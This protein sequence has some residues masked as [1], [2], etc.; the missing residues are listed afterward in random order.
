MFERKKYKEFAKQQ[1]KNRW[2][3]PILITLIVT[4]ISGL[5]SI[6]NFVNPDLF[7]QYFSNSITYEEFVEG[8][9][10][11]DNPLS[12]MIDF[13]QTLISGILSVA[14]ANVYLKMSRSPEKIT[15]STFIQG[16][17][18]WSKAVLATLW[19]FLWTF[20][21]SLLFIIPGLIKSIA[22][23]QIYYLITE[24]P[25]L[26][27]TKAMKISILITNGHK[28]DLFVMYL[29]FLGWCILAAI[30][31]GIGFIF[32]TPYMEMTFVNAYHAMLKEA[33]DF[34]KLR[35]EDLTE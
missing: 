21:W 14:C 32:L 20:L 26:S 11:V 6:K 30:P 12:F 5:L 27:V 3:I 33:V 18:L 17:N 13:L 19:T 8:Y 25:N 34:G 22:Y 4:V 24:Y 1:L 2:G 35:P 23:S 31:A 9:V 7:T 28:A 29:S 16:L 10:S 15:F